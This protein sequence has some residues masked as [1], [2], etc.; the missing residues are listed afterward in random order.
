MTLERLLDALESAGLGLTVVIDHGDRLERVYANRCLAELMGLDLETMVRLPVLDPM[1]PAERE[2]L[3]ALRATTASGSPAPSLVETSIVRPDGTSVPLEVALGYT[4]DDGKKL[5]FAFMRDLSKNA[6]MARALRESEERFRNLA[7]T[8]PDSIAV[9]SSGRVVYA[10]PVARQHLGIRSAEDLTQC[11][12]E[13]FVTPE[14]RALVVEH[15]ERVR[16]GERPPPLPPIRVTG[17]D[18]QE[19]V[20]ETSLSLVTLDGEPAIFS[21]TRD[22]TERMRMQAELVKKDRLASV[23]ILAAGVAHELNNP[24]TSLG[25]QVRKLRSDADEHGFSESVRTSLEQIEEASRRMNTIIAD[26]LFMARP[27]DQPQAHVDVAQI[28][29]S[30]IALLRAG[31]VRCPEIVNDIATLP[32][33]RGYTSKLGQVFLNIL[34][35]AVQAVEDR[36]DGRIHVTARVEG[37]SIEISVRDNGEGIPSDVMPR[38]TQPFFSTK[39]TGTGLGLWI[40]QTLIAQHNGELEVSSPPG[41]G[42]TVTLRLPP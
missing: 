12:P 11:K 41:E 13:A 36:P 7:E 27:V 35:N 40:S 24:L 21:Y 33:I 10:N 42:T 30:T 4:R 34:R 15:L 22:I 18:E 9:Y 14:R 6:E 28:L 19:L 5:S 8:S 17:P 37:G 16:R 25:M 23:G 26:L 39:P 1:P 31:L 2:R 29:T 32:P 38:V 3:R 20:L